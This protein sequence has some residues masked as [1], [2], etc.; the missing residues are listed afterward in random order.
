MVAVVV[1]VEGDREGGQRFERVGGV[2]ADEFA[3]SE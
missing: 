1:V 3:G 2:D